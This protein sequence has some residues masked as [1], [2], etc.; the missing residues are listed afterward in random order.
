MSDDL[1]IPILQE[2]ANVSKR[3]VETERVTVRTSIEEERVVVRE[4]LR[5]EQV[6]VTRVPIDR[7][8]SV[9]PQ[10]RSSSRSDCSWWKSCTC[11]GW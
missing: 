6:T 2:E 5:R 11:S 9:A 1:R 4:E 7:E 10:I 3:V 8:V